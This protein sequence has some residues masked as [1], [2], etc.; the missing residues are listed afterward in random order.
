[1]IKEKRDLILIGG[2]EECH[3]ICTDYGFK[4]FVT[5][6]EMAAIYPDMVPLSHKAGYPQAEK[7]IK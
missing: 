3:H 7:E 6:Q 4:N 2:S 5:V 1:M